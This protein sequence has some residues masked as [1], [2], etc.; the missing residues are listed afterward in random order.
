ME[1][2]TGTVCFRNTMRIEFKDW[3]RISHF[4]DYRWL[5]FTDSMKHL[6]AFWKLLVEYESLHSSESDDSWY[7]SSDSMETHLVV[8]WSQSQCKKQKESERENLEPIYGPAVQRAVHG[9]STYTCY[10]EFYP[11]QHLAKD[12]IEKA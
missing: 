3:N 11:R 9:A 12:L 2:F 1:L 6:G 10:L 4:D 5:I 7:E 8:P